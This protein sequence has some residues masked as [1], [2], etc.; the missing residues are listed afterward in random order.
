MLFSTCV[1]NIQGSHS[2]G[3]PAELLEFYVRPG[4]CGMIS[5]F[6]LKWQE[7]S[8][9]LATDF[10]EQVPYSVDWCSPLTLWL[11]S[12]M[13]GSYLVTIADQA[14]VFDI[15]VRT[16]TE[17]TWKNWKILKLDWKTPGI[18]LIQ[19]SGN[20]DIKNQLLRKRLRDV[21]TTRRYTNPRLPYLTLHNNWYRNWP[22]PFLP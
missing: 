3:K 8:Y 11:H 16:I 18:F 7:K 12:I 21:F 6:M 5:R 9:P 19:K 1:A 17:S 4:I 14:N 20:P 15:Q 13:F 10:L 22:A 2:P